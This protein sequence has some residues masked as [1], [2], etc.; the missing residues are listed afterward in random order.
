MSVRPV[1]GT[2]DLFPDD[3]RRHRR[4]IETARLAS[5]AYGFGEIQ[6]PIFE[7]TDVFA[8]TLGDVS[9]VVTKEMYTF[10]DRG[11]EQ[12]T[13]RPENTAGVARAYISAK[14][15]NELPL[16]YFYA[17]PMFR[18]ER[19]QKGRQR[20][21]HQI[22]VELFGV[23]GP[24]GDVEVIA[25]AAQILKQLNMLDQTVLHLNTLGDTE[26]RDAYRTA[27]ADY[28]SAYKG[29]L[30]EDS[31]NRLERN[32]LRI[33]DSKNKGDQT[34]VAGAPVFD[35]FLTPDANSFF[36]EVKSRLDD[37]GVAYM[38]DPRLVR[39]LDYY[40]HTAFE[41]VT[42]AL[43]A[44][45]TV[46]GGGRYDG[47]VGIMGG[48]KTPGVGW[49]GGIERL[50]MLADQTLAAPTAPRPVALAPIGEAAERRL[51]TLAFE[52]R[53]TGVATDMGYS[54]NLK[55]RMTRAGKVNARLA[56][57]L[58]DDELAKGVATLRDMD[59]GEQS[60]IALDALIG[61]L[62]S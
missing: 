56:V 2:V 33:L 41:F 45:G 15:Q 13:L 54:G 32:P 47:L 59:S 14:L 22:G 62:T 35:D 53:A 17:G 49:A 27:L 18:Y 11:D 21:F 12:L 26:S 36:T 20:Q 46:I 50:V 48:P 30:S 1:R 38:R 40:C 42:D 39:G 29:D 6:T 16:K 44:Q 9:D 28:F 58:G 61:R 52:L 31:L 4:V 60:E 37:L 25:M 43:G 19:P 51:Q 7:F 5:E 23:P 34:I 10:S 55:R 24:A 3:M 57:I 8:R